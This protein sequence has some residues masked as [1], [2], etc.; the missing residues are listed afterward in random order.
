M[1]I[2]I[3]GATGRTGRHIL[4]NALALGHQVTAV[5]R[6]PSRIG[7]RHPN[8]TV[9]AGDLLDRRLVDRAVRGRDAVLC[10]AG[11]RTGSGRADPV[12]VYS[13]GTRHILGAMARHQVRRL[14]AISAAGTENTP[15][16]PWVMRWILAARLG[17]VFRDMARMEREIARN[18][19]DWTVVRPPRLLDIP[20][21]G[22]YRVAL[23]ALP[24]GGK[25]IAC[26]DLAAFMLAQVDQA[27]FVHRF[28]TIAY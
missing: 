17:E 9:L 3:F 21:T 27:D 16:V 8:L 10:A 25:R 2:T 18:P 24:P 12:R 26:A 5:A 22:E 14:I 19:L 13:V 7:G 15:S 1:N 11:A 4:G 20:P 28:V 23:D 6:D